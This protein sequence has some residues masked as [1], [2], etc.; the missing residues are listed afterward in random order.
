MRALG[1]NSDSVCNGSLD[2]RVHILLVAH[3]LDVPL[4]CEA[5]FLKGGQRFGLLGLDYVQQAS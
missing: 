2:G 1:A 3:V 4:L 5:P